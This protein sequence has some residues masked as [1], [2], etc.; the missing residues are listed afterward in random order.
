MARHK[1]GGRGG[2]GPGG[3]EVLS[4]IRDVSY[5]QIQQVEAPTSWTHRWQLLA[6]Q[7]IYALASLCSYDNNKHAA[8]RWTGFAHNILL[9]S[10]GRTRLVE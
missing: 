4:L 7:H 9:F 1:E 8:S 6:H 3:D 5:H 2:P 10:I